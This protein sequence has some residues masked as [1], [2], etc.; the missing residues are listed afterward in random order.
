[1]SELVEGVAEAIALSGNGGTWDNWYT[2]E[3]KEFHRRRARAAIAAMRIPTEEMIY[4]GE[5]MLDGANPTEAW[6]RMIDEA[7]SAPSPSPSRADAA[8]APRP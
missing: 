6:Q 4:I 8:S 2:P 5:Y 7:L 1:M 3:Q